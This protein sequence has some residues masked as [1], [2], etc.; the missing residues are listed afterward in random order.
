MWQILAASYFMAF[1]AALIKTARYFADYRRH[2]QSF[3]LVGVPA[4]LALALAL[5]LI[6]I[7]SGD[8]PVWRGAAS[9]AAIRGSI[10]VWAVLSL[11]FEVLYGRTYLVVTPKTLPGGEAE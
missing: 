5:A 9:I 6:V 7:R 3:Y 11:V 10:V 4:N 8:D 1:I 2:R